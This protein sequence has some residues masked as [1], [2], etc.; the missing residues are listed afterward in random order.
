MGIPVYDME[1][2]IRKIEDRVKELENQAHPPR[3]FVTCEDCKQKVKEEDN[4]TD[5]S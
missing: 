3:T 5:N 2:R 1:A 4:G